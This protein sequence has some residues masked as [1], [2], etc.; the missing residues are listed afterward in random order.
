MLKVRIIPTLL[1]KNVTLVK[2]IGFDSWRR[3]GTVLPAVKVYNT[4]DV[5]E[6]VLV[7][8]TASQEQ[9]EPD[10]ETIADVSQECFVPLT[11]GGGVATLEAI[12]KLLRAGA[13]KVTINT[14]AFANPDLVREGSWRFGAQCIVVIMD[15]RKKA[16]G[17]YECYSNS[18][19]RATGWEPAAWVQNVE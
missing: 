19:T 17:V 1:W 16:D 5:D 13:D 3:V 11:V 8:I 9:R 12:R 7:D 2:G 18:G 15:A 6:L 14:A 10:Y 4:R